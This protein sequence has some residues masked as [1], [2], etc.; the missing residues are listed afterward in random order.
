[1]WLPPNRSEVCLTVWAWSLMS[2]FIALCYAP[3]QPS[4]TLHLYSDSCWT[5][6]SWR[7]GTKSCVALESTSQLVSKRH[8]SLYLLVCYPSIENSYY[9][10]SHSTLLWNSANEVKPRWPTT[11]YPTLGRGGFGSEGWP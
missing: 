1:M 3:G 8:P 6:G 5:I 11:H 9:D 7:A 4:D 2:L 10:H